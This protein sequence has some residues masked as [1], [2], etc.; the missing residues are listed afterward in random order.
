M[1][2]RELPA[3]MTVGDGGNA[4]IAT[5][6]VRAGGEYLRE[7]FRNG[8]VEGEFSRTDVKANVDRESERRIKAVLDANLSTYVFHG[9][10]S[11][12][13]GEGDSRWIVDPLDGTN[14]FASGYSKFATALAVVVDD[15]PTVSAIYEPLTDTLYLAQRGMGATRNGVSLRAERS[16]PLEHGTVAL[17]LGLS[18]VT[19]PAQRKQ[20]DALERALRRQCKRV[21][22][23]WAPCVDWG[24]LAS[25][26]IEGIVCIG[27]GEYEHH[28]G[29]LLAAE[30][31]IKSIDTVK[32]NG[33][34]V[35]AADFE[36]A[37][38][39]AAVVASVYE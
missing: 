7:A 15:T 16:L 31:G 34:Y 22:P 38:S 21:V 28:A 9:E 6:A 3:R 18:V 4:E 20:A 32:T 29:S 19:D 10:E 2:T 30:S 23:T 12:V 11:G 27:P 13:S 35:G 17:V 33:R 1:R 36:T 26:S 14:N 24:L 37:E 25:G 39:L 8:S 5:T